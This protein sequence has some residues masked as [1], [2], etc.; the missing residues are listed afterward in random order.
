MALLSTLVSITPH[1][2]RRTSQSETTVGCD[3][4]WCHH[5]ALRCSILF[6]PWFYDAAMGWRCLCRRSFSA[7]RFGF[8]TSASDYL[9]DRFTVARR[10]TAMQARLDFIGFISAVFYFRIHC[11]HMRATSVTRMP[12]DHLPPEPIAVP[13]DRFVRHCFSDGRTF[14]AEAN[15]VGHTAVTSRWRPG[16]LR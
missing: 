1:E 7:H 4:S 8:H 9:H 3:R 16:F 6:Q 5:V 12:T 14:R 15:G 2:H 13:S 11:C 10:S